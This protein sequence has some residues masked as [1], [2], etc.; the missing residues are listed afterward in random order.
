VSTDDIPIMRVPISLPCEVLLEPMLDPPPEAERCATDAWWM[1]GRAMICTEHLRG[2]LGD[3]WDEIVGDI[4][5][6]PSEL[7]PFDQ[8]HRYSQDQ[9]RPSWE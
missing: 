1:I 7:L 5:L 8:R 3:D 4:P 9:A 2:V 6:N